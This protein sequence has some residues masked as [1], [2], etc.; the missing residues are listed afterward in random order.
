[1]GL[2]CTDVANYCMIIDMKKV[3]T[4][5]VKLQV[6]LLFKVDKQLELLHMHD[7]DNSKNLAKMLTSSIQ[8]AS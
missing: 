6:E 8:I 7:Y 2:L 1:M 3:A 4:K 5:F